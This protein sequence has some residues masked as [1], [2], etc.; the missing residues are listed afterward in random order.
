[1]KNYYQILDNEDQFLVVNKEAL[2][3]VAKSMERPVVQLEKEVYNTYK[4]Y[5]KAL[6]PLDYF[7][8]G[9]VFLVKKDALFDSLMADLH[10]EQFRFT[11]DVVVQ[12]PYLY[13]ENQITLSLQR[14]AAG[15]IIPKENEI[16]FHLDLKIVYEYK[17]Y[18]HLR[19]TTHSYWF[20]ALLFTLSYL[21]NPVIGDR[22]YGSR[23]SI[24]LST[25]KKQRYKSKIGKKEE[26]LI[27]R[28][29]IHLSVVSYKGKEY[30]APLVKDMRSVFYH[31]EKYNKP[32]EEA[33]FQDILENLRQ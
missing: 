10:Q 21:G 14:N 8:S 17:D 23:D 12:K 29:I 11:Y 32:I 20:M 2:V 28:P 4:T 6:Y 16:P 22:Y 5:Y 18:M 7:I 25:L 19:V 13:K 15:R 31:L 3:D 26:P 1:M 33:F 27:K 30:E 24:Y 9:V